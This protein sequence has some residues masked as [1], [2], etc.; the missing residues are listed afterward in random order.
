MAADGSR[1]YILIEASVS[2]KGNTFFL[3]SLSLFTI[4]KNSSDYLELDRTYIS[5][6]ITG[7]ECGFSMVGLDLSK[8]T[9]LRGIASPKAQSHQLSELIWSSDSKDEVAFW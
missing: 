4:K 2:R 6:T 1:F 5:K 9:P 7:K 3:V 8:L